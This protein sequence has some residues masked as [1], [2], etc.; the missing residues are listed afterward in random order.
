MRNPR[1]IPSIIELN[2]VMVLIHALVV[3]YVNKIYDIRIIYG[4][5]VPAQNY[6]QIRVL[7][8]STE[9]CYRYG[10]TNVPEY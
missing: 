6:K 7:S 10:D 2:D 8:C 5:Q 9:P 1:F 4:L 3:T